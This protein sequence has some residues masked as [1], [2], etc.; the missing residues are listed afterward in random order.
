MAEYDFKYSVPFLYYK[1]LVFFP[2]AQARTKNVFIVTTVVVIL[3][4]Q[5]LCRGS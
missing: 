1:Y 4:V 5:K 3:I 2:Q